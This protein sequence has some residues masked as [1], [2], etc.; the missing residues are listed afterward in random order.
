MRQLTRGEPLYKKGEMANH[1]YFLVRGALH[2]TVVA[3]SQTKMSHTIEENHF[4]GF[5]ESQME[6]NDFATSKANLTEVIQ[7]DTR[8][9]RT[10]ITQT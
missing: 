2:L 9:Y 1:F 5:R 10:L 6:R 7:I 3:D 4:F 8:V